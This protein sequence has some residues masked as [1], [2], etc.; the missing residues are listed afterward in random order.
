VDRALRGPGA[1]IEL[2]VYD[3]GGNL[4]DAGGGNGTAAVVNS[5]G[6]SIAGSPFTATRTALG[7]YQVAIPATLTTLDVYSVTWNLP[8]T[9]TRATEFELVGSFLFTQ[10][11]LRGLDPVLTDE[12]AFPDAAVVDARENAERR[13]ER[14]AEVSFTLRGA[15]EAIDGSGRTSIVSSYHELRRLVSATVDGVAITASDVVVFPFGE[16]YRAAGWTEGRRNVVALLEHGY[17]T[18]PEPIRR[19]GLLYAR[20]VLLRS[21]LEQS[22]RATAVFTDIGGYRLTLA[23]RDGPT[24]LPEVD[25]VLAQFGRRPA[26]SFA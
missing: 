14:V 21:A 11:E 8:D 13:F 16:L 23:G 4:V 3:A 24:G 26:G 12:T 9:T 2:R 22:D 18:V 10:A 1:T 15:R 5:A 17:T 7:T 19:A 6:L 25:A 20:S